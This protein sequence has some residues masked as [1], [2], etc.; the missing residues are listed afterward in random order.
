MNTTSQSCLFLANIHEYTWNTWIQFSRISYLLETRE[1]IDKNAS[2]SFKTSNTFKWAWIHSKFRSSDYYFI[3]IHLNSMWIHLNT[4]ATDFLKISQF[5][6]IHWNIPKSTWILLN[7]LYFTW[8]HVI[9]VFLKF[10][11]SLGFIKVL[12]KKLEYT[13]EYMWILMYNV[14]TLE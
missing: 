12:F 7:T 9:T 14:N 2:K 1:Y 10:H 3:W 6:G 11:S 13:N 8:I 4:L 5:F